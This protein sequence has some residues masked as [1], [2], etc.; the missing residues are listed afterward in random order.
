[1]YSAPWLQLSSPR[2]SRSPI[3]VAATHQ[4]HHPA[5]IVIVVQQSS[6]SSARSKSQLCRI[7]ISTFIAREEEVRFA[8]SRLHQA[9][10]TEHRFSKPPP[11]TF[12]LVFPARHTRQNRASRVFFVT[13]LG[14]EFRDFWWA[15]LLG[16]SLDPDRIYKIGVLPA[17][18]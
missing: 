3:V 4:R 14:Q 1:M 13:L 2:E 8:F 12:F 18:P 10:A 9:A 7:I 6:S 15:L 16:L 5:I 11:P 17:Q